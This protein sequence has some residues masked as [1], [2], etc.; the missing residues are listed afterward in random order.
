MKVILT[1][2]RDAENWSGT[3]YSIARWKPGWF[4]HPTFPVPLA[5]FHKGKAM[6]HLAPD[7]YR[8]KYEEILERERWNLIDYLSSPARQDLQLVLVCWCNLARQEGYD[9]LFCHRILVGYWIER[10]LPD[11]EVVYADGAENPVW[12]RKEYEVE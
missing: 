4:P 3:K 8:T 9:K 10:N 5:P 1:S 7:E 2:F 11:I 12:P 6:K